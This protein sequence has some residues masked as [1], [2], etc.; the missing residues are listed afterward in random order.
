MSQ[1]DDNQGKGRSLK[2][3]LLVFIFPLF[4]SVSVAGV[5]FNYFD[6]RDNAKQRIDA[7]IHSRRMDLE[8]LAMLPELKI[9]VVES[10][11]ILDDEA[12][13]DG[14]ETQTSFSE[15]LKRLPTDTPSVLRVFTLEGDTLLSMENGHRKY[16]GSAPIPESWIKALDAFSNGQKPEL[17]TYAFPPQAKSRITD[18]FPVFSQ[19]SR[20][21]IGALAYEY[22][23]PVPALMRPVR[24]SLA[25]NIF[26]AVATLLIAMVIAY[27]FSNRSV[28]AM[29]HLTGQVQKMLGGDLSQAVDARGRGEIVTLALSIESLRVL[30]K[31]QIELL[32]A[33]ADEL[34][35]SLGE[36]QKTKIQLQEERDFTSVIVNETPSFICRIAVDGSLLYMNPAAEQMSGYNTRELTGQEIDPVLFPHSKDRFIAAFLKKTG[37]RIHNQEHT[38]TNRSG[39]RRTLLWSS[40]ERRDSRNKVNEVILIGNDITEIKNVEN[41]LRK[42]RTISDR[43][44]Y[45]SAI[46][47]PQ[48]SV[49]YINDAYAQMHGY[50]AEELIGK[51]ISLFFGSRYAK[52]QEY[53]H[54]QLMLRGH[55]PVEE[56]T[57]VGR[58]GRTIPLLITSTVVRNELGQPSFLSETAIDISEK[59]VLE[60]QLQIRQRMDSLGTLA[61]GI[62]HDFNNLLSGITGYLDLLHLRSDNFTAQQKRYLN[63]LTAAVQR[64]A[65]LVR[66]FQLLAQNNVTKKRYL[67][68]SHIVGEV[69]GFLQKTTHRNIQKQNLIESGR[70]FV[71]GNQTELSQ[72]FLNFAVNAKE[73]LEAKGILTGDYIRA[74]ARNVLISETRDKNFKGGRYVHISFSDS[75]CGMSESIKAR[76]FDPLFSSKKMSERKGQGLGLSMV[77]NII[78]NHGGHVSVDSAPGEGATFHIYLPAGA[79]LGMEM[80]ESGQ[81][82]SG[83]ETILFVDDEQ[84][85]RSVIKEELEQLGYTVL[86]AADGAEA[87]QCYR[88]HKNE[89][90]LTIL[91]LIMPGMSGEE[92]LKS[93]INLDAKAKIIISSGHT[94]HHLSK[95]IRGMARAVLNKPLMLKE[96]SQAVR[97]I[98]DNA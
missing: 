19:N 45:G 56:V 38:L 82:P 34:K 26:G 29:R 72:V 94:D 32:S 74:E 68:I 64:A 85:L 3:L 27:L 4:C 59:K 30:L 40:V 6:A 25:F 95:E 33:N 79:P 9:Y 92:V 20:I 84:M 52:Q 42:F 75:G 81:M 1:A 11:R 88:E 87:L 7:Y 24:R 57:H 65:E 37:K 70:Y 93:I 98:I 46:Y 60:E 39:E 89:I 50:R 55:L 83:S 77:Y 97:K 96:L 73:A 53:L 15:Y 63:Q 62:A 43:S 22:G 41:E 66:Q 48:G 12:A 54:E 16:S 36:A 61:G 58:N 23:L 76:V 17:P 67:D 86:T 44:S 5:L 90:A 91:D 31:K 78:K 80:E 69:F 18:L 35:A 2:T 47:D 51:H 28:H 71:K 21:L 8:Y 14:V 49:T 13:R 10:R